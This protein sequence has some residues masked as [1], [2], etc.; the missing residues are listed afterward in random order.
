VD[1][2]MKKV[3]TSIYHLL[4]ADS[5]P[6]FACEVA[7][8][9]QQRNV[10][11][12]SQIA[13][14]SVAAVI[15]KWLQPGERHTF[16]QL[17]PF[18]PGALDNLTEIRRAAL[19]VKLEDLSD[20]KVLE[21]R[22]FDISLYPTTT[23]FLDMLDEVTKDWKDM[24]SYIG[25]F[26]TPNNV[27]LQRFVRDAAAEVDTKRFV[28]YQQGPSHVLPQVRGL[29]E[30]FKKSGIVYN[31]FVASYGGEPGLST[32]RVQLPRRTLASKLA[33]CIDGQVLFASALEFIG[34]SAGLVYILSA[35]KGHA[36]VGWETEPNSG[37]WQYLDTTTIVEKTFE[38]TMAAANG[39]AKAFE[40][41]SKEVNDRRMFRQHALAQLRAAGITPME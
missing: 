23:V 20:D 12:T 28:G 4:S 21:H 3:P 25:A 33:N 24:T 39:L 40:D 8:N 27:E 6:L 1:T 17:P 9:D 29:F 14:Y 30:A 10:R 41:A 38:Q 35:G 22:T 15:N 7:N 16:T 34:L 37:D 32:Q 13:G 31:S 19:E 36:L 5:D 11:L 26:V 2:R 18:S